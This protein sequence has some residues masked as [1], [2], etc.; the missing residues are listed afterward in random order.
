MNKLQK[1]KKP[2]KETGILYEP[3]LYNIPD[4]YFTMARELGDFM[5]KNKIREIQGIIES[6][7][8]YTMK[9]YYEER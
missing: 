4:K 6:D 8:Y 7:H 9:Y 5:K 3:E 1:V 2:F